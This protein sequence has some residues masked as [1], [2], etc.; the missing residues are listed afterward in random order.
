V[1]ERIAKERGV[2]REAIV[3]AWILRHPAGIMPVLGT[4][5]PDRLRACCQGAEVELSRIEWYQIYSAAMGHG[6]P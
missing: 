1:I 2:S 5:N 4:T 3:I 6:V